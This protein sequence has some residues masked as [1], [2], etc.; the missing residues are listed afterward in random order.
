MAGDIAGAEEQISHA[1]IG[2]TEWAEGEAYRILG[3]L[4]LIRGDF[5]GAAEAFHKSR[6]RGWNPQPGLAL[7]RFEQGDEQEAIRL[8]QR[9]LAEDDWSTLQRRSQLTIQLAGMNARVGQPGIA[10]ELLADLTQPGI[11]MMSPAMQSALHTA[12]GEILLA[13]EQ[14]QEAASQFERAIQGWI[15]IKAPLQA[16]AVRQRL[17]VALAHDDVRAAM[18]ELELANSEY[19]RLGVEARVRDR[20]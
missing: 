2:N 20:P 14:F 11:A 19:R 17:A 13:R 12:R 4:K 3:N 15:A 10:E 5:E 6:Q 8:L 9:S 18:T 7:L 1:L 16:C